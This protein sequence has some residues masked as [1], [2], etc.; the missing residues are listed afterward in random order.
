MV[1]KSR[2]KFAAAFKAKVALELIAGRRVHRVLIASPAG[3]LL[4][5]WDQE[6][7]AR[8]GLRFRL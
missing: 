3:P 4:N 7:R 1:A 6:L 5:Q 8:F 2:R